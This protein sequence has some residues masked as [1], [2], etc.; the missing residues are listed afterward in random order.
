MRREWKRL[1]LNKRNQAF[2]TMQLSGGPYS[3]NRFEAYESSLEEGK[4]A[5]DPHKMKA[6][7][8][9]A[10]VKKR[11]ES[12]KLKKGDK[13]QEVKQEK[14]TMSS[15]DEG[16]GVDEAF[17][18]PTKAK[19]LG[20]LSPNMKMNQK[21]MSLQ[22]SEPGS[23]RQKKQTKAT[24]QMNKTL[25]SGANM[26]RRNEEINNEETTETVMEDNQRMAMYSRALGVMGAQYSGPALEE[27][28]E[29]PDF[30]KKDEDKDDDK[31]D[32]KDK[33][34]KK[35]DKDYDGDGEVESS[36]KEHAGSVH[37]AIQR[38]KGGKADGKDTRKEEVEITKEAVVEFMVSEGY[39]DNTVSA[40]ILHSH[41]SDEFLARIEESM[42]TD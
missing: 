24:N 13:K 7:V 5:S 9:A 22:A 28:K 35:A 1:R 37:N 39:A 6:V 14:A 31:D 36:E 33:K 41:I 2:S 21:S 25:H 16:Y 15:V 8:D 30:M 40:E 27:K 4:G 17:E 3:Y 12:A 38:K 18:D 32:K 34:D 26:A 11:Q 19:R 20:G 23:A 29:L 42:I 10:A